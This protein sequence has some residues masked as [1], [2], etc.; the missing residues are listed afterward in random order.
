[1]QLN[2]IFKWCKKINGISIVPIRIHF[3]NWDG[4]GFNLLTI[5][6]F[7]G[8]CIYERSAI[9]FNVFADYSMRGKEVRIMGGVFF[10]GWKLWSKVIRN[11]KDRCEQCDNWCETKE[12]YDGDIPYCSEACRDF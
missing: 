1:M 2:K 6:L 4:Y 12:F 11:K 7:R 5:G 9:F 10:M 3:N 8:G